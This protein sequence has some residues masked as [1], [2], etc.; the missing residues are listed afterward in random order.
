MDSAQDMDAEA[1]A[2]VEVEVE[3][4]RNNWPMDLHD[5][6]IEEHQDTRY[7]GDGE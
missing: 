4:M 5:V 1:G 7:K 6:D 3:E 2:E